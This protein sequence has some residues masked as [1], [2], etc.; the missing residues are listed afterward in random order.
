MRKS[1]PCPFLKK[2]LLLSLISILFSFYLF[3]QP[4][5]SSFSPASGP[6]G[7]SV[8]ISGTNFSTVLANNIVFFGTVRANVTA[9][10]SNS[11]T[12]TVPYGAA[13]KPF[14]VTTGGLTA[15]SSQPFTITFPGAGTE[16]TPQSFGYLGRADSVGAGIETT[17]YAIGD[18][19]NDGKIDMVTVDRINGFVA[20]YKNTSAGGSITFTRTNIFIDES[21]RSVTIGDVDSDGMPEIIFSSLNTNTVSVLRNTSTTG[22]ISFAARVTFATAVQPSEI[23][24]TD[25]DRDGK[26][27]MV[28]NTI[29]LE[30]YVSVF[31]NTGSVGNISFATKID[32]A[33]LGGSIETISASDVDGDGKV[34]ILVPNFSLNSVTIFPNSSVPGTISFA[35]KT[36]IPT[37][38]HPYQ[39][40]IADLNGDGKNDI[41][42][43]YVL[44][45]DNVSVIRNTSTPGNISFATRGDYPTG[46]FTEGLHIN[47]MDGDGK[48]D[49]LVASGVD[50]LC[51]FRNTSAGS[52][53]T[54]ASIKKTPNFWDSPV[55]SADFNNDGR[56]DLTFRSGIFRVTIWENKTHYPQIVSFSPT[57]SGSN[58]TVTITG[59]NFTGATAV[60]FGGVPAASFTIVNST[61]ITAVVGTGATG[62]VA[63]TT[64][65]GTARL[66]GYLYYPA[67]VINSF[68]PTT[69][70]TGATVT[71][72]GENFNGV[73]AVSFGGVPATSFTVV[74][75]TTIT[76]VVGTGASGS[77]SV[78]TPGGTATLAGLIYVP[79]PIISSFTPTSGTVG[80]VITI[81]GQNFSGAT[82]VL[83][84]GIAPA[85]FNV[86]SSTQIQATILEGSSGDVSVTT[87]GGTASLAGFS[88]IPTPVPIVTSFSPVLG[89]VG[90]TVTITGLNFSSN[91]AENTVYFG[92]TKA[93]VINATTTSLSVVVP[94]GSTSEPI[95]VTVK[96][97][98]GYSQIPFGVT[99]PGGGNIS[100][101]SF[102]APIP[103]STGTQPIDL[104]AADIDNDGKPDIVTGN[105]GSGNM[106]VFL[107]NSTGGNIGFLPRQDFSQGAPYFGHVF[108]EIDGDGK[109]DLVFVSYSNARVSV[110]RNVSMPGTVNFD[111]KK[112]FVLPNSP[113]AAD[114]K[115]LD[116]DGK[117]DLAI[118]GLFGV[119]VL[120]S[121]SVVANISFAPPVNIFSGAQSFQLAIDDVD[122]DSKPDIVAITGFRDSIAVFRNTSTT[123]TIAFSA[124]VKFPIRVDNAGGFGPTDIKISD[125]DGDG[126]A[127]I[128]VANTNTSKSV[129]LYKNASTPGN[130]SFPNR[131]DLMTGNIEPMRLSIHDMDGDGKSDITFSHEYVPAAVAVIKNNSIP[132]NLSFAGHVVFTDNSNYQLSG[133]A[134][135]DLDG[136]NRP[137]IISTRSTGQTFHV[138]KNNTDKPQIT[139]FSPTYGL[140]GTVVTITGINMGGATS[141]SFGGVPAASF[142]VNSPT[143][144][145]AVVG[146]GATGNVT[147]VN[148]KGTAN[149]AGYFYG[150]LP[151]ITS[152]TPTSGATFA[153]INITGTNLN[154]VT[155]VYFGNVQGS[156]LIIHSPT[157][158]SASVWLGA[159]GYVKINSP[160]G[161][162]SLAG[163]TYL[164]PA[165]TIS[166]FSPTTATTGDTIS[167]WGSNFIDLSAITF[168]G[169]PATSIIGGS[170]AY[171]RAVVGA[172]ASGDVRVTHPGGSASMPGFTYVAIP[173][174]ISFTPNNA[175]TGGTVTITGTNFTGATQVKF[176][177]VAA[178][179][180]TI[181]NATTINAVVGTGA[182][183]DVSVTTPGGTATLGGFTYNVVTSTGPSPGGNSS[184]LIVSPNPTSEEFVIRYPIS[185][186]I[187][188]LVLM[189]MLGQPVKIISLAR[190][191]SQVQMD[192]RAVPAGVYKL[193]WNDGRRKF[194]QTVMVY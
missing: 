16:F 164:P 53:I 65:I 13:Y 14:S 175:A 150:L 78:I 46:N 123:G 161:A 142:V 90:T 133:V 157:S 36:D 146:A 147:V 86:V 11:I 71:I 176:G 70:N 3:A 158:I 77:V 190:N 95:S 34:D 92:A 152:F 15:Y 117:T 137:E 173:T 183:G 177:G 56:P 168:G 182:S 106:S 27:D 126:K 129:S 57:V 29:N 80:A 32:L 1:M 22:N 66:E 179:S 98:T 39:A 93:T 33:S 79:P 171:C 21:L 166:S 62:E 42:V 194:R 50:S 83:F 97:R 180:F 162:D 167:I 17:K 181:M 172:G 2:R 128:I 59:Q 130:I 41:A 115:D 178:A 87:F 49:L 20:I 25:L 47:D 30:G 185:S 184:E 19:D 114:Y 139:A 120:K 143:S 72:S 28:V 67:P 138:F 118:S 75:P 101:N 134:T 52:S 8:T 109:P 132:G 37:G 44:V 140:S 94:A 124:P 107:N 58:A 51:I 191:S 5:I 127:E 23:V 48:P 68:N 96:Y 163:F 136:D 61:T 192:V 12:V 149:K 100:E 55:F 174:I 85:S 135:C 74:N 159:S 131:T 31:R 60:S 193:I 104:V 156:N 102:D 165:P 26:P 38:Q 169:V 7:T 116:G 111:P 188:T 18:L 40:A 69:V 113:H 45:S 148:A 189:D 103:F 54:F 6:V 119:S 121:T 9:A 63:V 43:N 4:T 35:T 112:D 88:F 170:T 155:E 110:L 153:V 99:F 141:V 84:E 154:Y 10:T 81:T 73:T 89:E 144:I 187:A 105:Y 64:P 122:G 145:T 76:A 108:T 151:K 125:L 160:G 82:Q 186:R 24:I 91:P